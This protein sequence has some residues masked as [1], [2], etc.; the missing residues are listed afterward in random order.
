[1]R[2]SHSASHPSWSPRLTLLGQFQGGE[3]EDTQTQVIMMITL[4]ARQNR[5]YNCDYGDH[6]VTI[7]FMFINQSGESLSNRTM[8]VL[9]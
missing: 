1:M 7:E 6:K 3:A 5:N 8:W 4:S 9:L 2:S